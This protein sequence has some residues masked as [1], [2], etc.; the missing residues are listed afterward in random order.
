MCALNIKIE[1]SNQNIVSYQCSG[2]TEN[3]IKVLNE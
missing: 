1:I 2:K 3:F